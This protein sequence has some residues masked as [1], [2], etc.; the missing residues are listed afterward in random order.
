M[1]LVG[2]GIL[3]AA[4]NYLYAVKTLLD[5]AGRELSDT[6]LGARADATHSQ[7]ELN[8]PSWMKVKFAYDKKCLTGAQAHP[9]IT[10]PE[11]PGYFS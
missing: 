6:T 8:S 9:S 10:V 1:S 5:C 3:T 7:V 11:I 4:P 2:K